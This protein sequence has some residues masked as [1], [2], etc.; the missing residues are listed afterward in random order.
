M[1]GGGSMLVDTTQNI[2]GTTEVIRPDHYQVANAV[3]AAWSQ[4]SGNTVIKNIVVS[5]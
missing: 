4:V 2:P 1:V 3:G 5:V